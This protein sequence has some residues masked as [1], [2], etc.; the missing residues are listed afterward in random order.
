[1]SREE[2][3]FI[4][5]CIQRAYPNS[6]LSFLSLN[7]KPAE[8]SAPWEHPDYGSFS[9]E[10]KKLLT[11]ARLFSEVMHGTALSYNVQLAKL[12]KDDE[13]VERHQKSFNNWVKILPLKEIEGWQLTQLWDLTVGH[14]YT[15]TPQ[16]RSFVQCWV[17]Y[18]LEYPDPNNLLYDT[19]ALNLIKRREM[20]LKG[21]RSRFRNQRALEQWGGSSGVRK[22]LDY[23]WPNIKVLLDDLDQGMNRYEKC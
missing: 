22:K 16:M 23:R 3:E 21:P 7:S 9:D 17:D 8:T 2:A 11:H 19:D 18:T 4:C 1:M 6:L 20:R 5:D 10:H 13:L 15:I 14:G 12:R